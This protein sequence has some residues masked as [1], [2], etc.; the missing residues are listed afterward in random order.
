MKIKDYKIEEDMMIGDYRCVVIG[1]ALGHRCGYIGLPKGHNFYGADIDDIPVGIHGGWTYSEGSKDFLIKSDRWWIGFDCAHGMD[2]KDLDLI[3][4]F[5]G[6]EISNHL[7]EMEMMFPFSG[8]V[9]TLDYV[10]NELRG[11]VID[12]SQL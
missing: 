3:K 10:S 6:N 5:S 9:K 11:A 1:L 4:S 2:G 12:L 7:I 8:N